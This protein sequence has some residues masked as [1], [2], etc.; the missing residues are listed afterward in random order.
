MHGFRVSRRTVLAGALAHGLVGSGPVPVASASGHDGIS[1]PRDQELPTFSRPDRLHALFMRSD[2]SADV[3]VL[4]TTLQGLVNRTRPQ[5]YIVRGDPSEGARTWLHDSGVP[6]KEYTDPWKVIRRFLDDAKED[7]VYDPQVVET[8]NVATTVAGLRDGVVVSPELAA[9]LTKP[10]YR[11]RV[12]DDFRGRF[13]SNLEATRWQFEHLFP[14]TSHRLVL[15]IN[16][17][18]PPP[19]IPPDNWK[20]FVEVAREERPIRDESNREVYELDLSAFAGNDK[21]FLRGS[22]TR[23]PR[24]AGAVRCTELSSPS[25]ARR[26]RTSGRV[27]SPSVRPCSTTAGRASSPSVRV[28]T[29]IGSPTAVP[30]SSTS[31]TSRPARGRSS[32]RSTCS[33]SSW[34]PRRRLRPPCRPTTGS[35]LR[36][37]CATM[38]SP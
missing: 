31:P 23:S 9:K 26:W 24:T 13:S 16:P 18:T 25:T 35:R 17:G 34:Y 29:P 6:Y 12:L 30:T 32:P 22:R 14:L 10:P 20:D 7:V 28:R 1:W 5:M 2:T 27:T 15:G 4:V 33:T 38:P 36:C 8:I 21:L 3:Q 19:P 37:R 11:K